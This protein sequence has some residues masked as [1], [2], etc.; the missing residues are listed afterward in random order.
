[1][2]F[3]NIPV[4][5]INLDSQPERKRRTEA[6]LRG[7]GFS[8]IIRVEAMVSSQHA[9]GCAVSHKKALALALGKEPF[10][11]FII[12]E[13]DIALFD[14][15]NI[16]QSIFEGLE[17][18]DAIYLGISKVGRVNG[19]TSG[20]LVASPVNDSFVRVYSMSS[21]HAIFYLSEEY[22]KFIH[23]AIDVAFEVGA[24]QDVVRA[25]S[26]KYFKVYALDTPLFFQD[27]SDNPANRATTYF[28]M[29][30]RA[31]QSPSK[32]NLSLQCECPQLELNQRPAG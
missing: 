11:P 5:Y 29:S 22:A 9:Q 4:Y 15:A 20:T 7:L 16:Q 17:G 31:V 13:D 3:T 6:A 12:V 2:T 1:M 10:S 8:N 14:G 28:S 24:H 32:E 21:A 30:S 26:M 25:D 23:K 19:Q 18:V 27:D